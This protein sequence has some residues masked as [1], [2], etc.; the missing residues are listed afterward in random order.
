MMIKTSRREL[1][2]AVGATGTPLSIGRR[3]PQVPSAVSDFTDQIGAWEMAA[4]RWAIEEDVLR[5]PEAGRAL[6]QRATE[7]DFN[8]IVERPS[9][10]W[11]RRREA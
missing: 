8:V 7:N 10:C 3:G 9:G 1:V 5:P 4:S 11:D 6:M 2:G